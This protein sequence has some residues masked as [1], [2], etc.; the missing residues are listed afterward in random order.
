MGFVGAGFSIR[1]YCGRFPNVALAN[2]I[3]MGIV[4]ATDHHQ[5]H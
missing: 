2:C 5:L 1:N 3:S 4:S